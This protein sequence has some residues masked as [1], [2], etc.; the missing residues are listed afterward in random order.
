MELVTTIGNLGESLNIRTQEAIMKTEAFEDQAKKL[1]AMT[2]KN[3]EQNNVINQLQEFNSS[4]SADLE[5]LKGELKIANN[6]NEQAIKVT[7]E[8]SA[9]LARAE[10]EVYKQKEQITQMHDKA[11]MKEQEYKLKEEKYDTSRREIEAY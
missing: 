1:E 3:N 11:I 2:E 10:A 4:L 8:V 9:N 6:E 5:Q 7:Q